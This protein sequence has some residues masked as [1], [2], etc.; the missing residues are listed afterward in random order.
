MMTTTT[1]TISICISNDPIHIFIETTT[2]NLPYI[3][4][5]NTVVGFAIHEEARFH[6]YKC[7]GETYSGPIQNR[8]FH[9]IHTIRRKQTT[10]VAVE[11]T[12]ETK[13]EMK[14]EMKADGTLNVPSGMK[15]DGTRVGT[16]R[17]RSE[18]TSCDNSSFHEHVDIPE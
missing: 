15:S 16:S 12:S 1:T 4:S 13:E 2:T 8:G 5:S 3:S 10:G 14:S 9:I 17:N 11:G 7:R 18:K 6:C